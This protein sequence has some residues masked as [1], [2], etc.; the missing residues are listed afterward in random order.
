MRDAGRTR[1]LHYIDPSVRPT[2]AAYELLGWLLEGSFEADA[3][4]WARGAGTRDTD[5]PGEG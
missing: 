2:G 1:E 4:V 5:E 3:P